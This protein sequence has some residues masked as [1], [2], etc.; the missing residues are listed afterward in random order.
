MG[1][2]HRIIRTAALCLLGLAAISCSND[3]DRR[4]EEAR[5]ELLRAQNLEAQRNARIAAQRITDEVGNL[6]PSNTQVVGVVLPRGFSPSFTLDHEWYYD[7][8]HPIGKVEKFFTERLDAT[9]EHPFPTATQY[10]VARMK[11]SPQMEPVGVKI[12]PMPGRADW[13]R[14]QINAKRPV[15]EKFPTAAEIEMELAKRRENFN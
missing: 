5:R 2:Q 3:A 14:I 12:Y 8:E 11:S 1:S 15:P 7:G 9:I 13:T 10:K 4:K 6:L